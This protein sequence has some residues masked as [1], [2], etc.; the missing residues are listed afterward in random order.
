MKFY[1]ESLNVVD[2][3]LVEYLTK[4]YF[5]CSD[6]V[7]LENE[8]PTT[9][10]ADELKGKTIAIGEY[11]LTIDEIKE[12][13]EAN[14]WEGKGKVE[15]NPLGTKV[16]VCVKFTDLK[17]NTDLV[18]IGGTAQSY[19]KDPQSNNDIVE[20]LFSDWGI[21]SLI[22]DTG[23]PYADQLQS[24]AT[25]GVKSLAEKLDLSKYYEYVVVGQNVWNAIGKQNI[26]ELYMPIALPKSIT[27]ESPVNVQISTMKFA[28][29]HATMDLIG[30]F[31]L[32]DCDVMKDQILVFGAPRI[33]ISPDRILPES[34]TL[35]LLSNLTLTDPD[36]DFEC[37]FKA[38]QDVINPT[39]GCYVSWHADKFELWALT[40]I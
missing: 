13:T 28:A 35:A 10:T 6:M 39:D 14:T 27:D 15:W 20:G 25:D 26:D 5:Q 16:M 11:Q 31:V 12:G 23:I 9:A 19:S 37:T 1:D 8:E 30:E 22:S 29:T 40:W 2:Y 7:E 33:C 24:A 36:S 17:I 32:P 18:V 21:D 4:N 3:A 38:P 34:G